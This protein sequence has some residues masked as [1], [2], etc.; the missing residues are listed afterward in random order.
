MAFERPEEFEAAFRA[1]VRG[2]FPGAHVYAVRLTLITVKLRLD[3]PG[4]RFV[5]VFFNA[6]NQRTDLSLIDEDRRLFGYDN[7]GGWHRHPARD[8]VAHESCE[9]PSL[10]TFLREVDAITRNPPF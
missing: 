9:P 4:A 2:V 10:E 8:P 6:R 7:L 1:A 3:F 5:D